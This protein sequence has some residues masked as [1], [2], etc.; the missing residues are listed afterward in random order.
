MT[1]YL[2]KV[3]T[4]YASKT[5]SAETTNSHYFWIDGIKIRVSDHQ[6]DTDHDL[7]I[8]PAVKGYVCIPNDV[9]FRK[10]WVCSNIRQVLG[11]IQG[12]VFARTLYSPTADQASGGKTSFMSSLNDLGCKFDVYTRKKLMH[13]TNHEVQKLLIKYLHMLESTEERQALVEYI[14]HMPNAGK[15]VAELNF[16]INQA[17]GRC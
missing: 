4:K 10:V 17:M 1:N 14:V 12:M 6:V 7:A 5:D 3:L 11:V 9:K 8:Y 15:Q 13:N 16:K 2:I